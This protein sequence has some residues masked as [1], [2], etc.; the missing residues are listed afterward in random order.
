MG[1]ISYM[2]EEEFLQNLG[3][4]ESKLR[5][6]TTKKRKLQQTKNTIYK[7]SKKFKDIRY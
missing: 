7:R 1:R 5:S 2:W 4:K 6:E 3:I